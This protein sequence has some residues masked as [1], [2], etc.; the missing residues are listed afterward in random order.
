MHF[1]GG[2][3]TERITVELVVATYTGVYVTM[4]LGAA[5]CLPPAVGP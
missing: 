2:F 3:D 5:F 4:L 1:N